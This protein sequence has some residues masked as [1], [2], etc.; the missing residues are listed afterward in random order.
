MPHRAGRRELKPAQRLGLAALSEGTTNELT[1]EQYQHLT[2]VSRSQAA[3]DLAEL[4]ETGLIERVGG[5]RSTRYRRRPRSQSSQRHW[6]NERIR[7]GLADFCATRTTWP[8]AGDFKAAGRADLYVAASRYGGIGVWASELG[9]S[10]TA[11][12]EQQRPARSLRPLLRWTPAGIAFAAVLFGVAGAVIQP[13]RPAPIREA[14]AAPDTPRV[15]APTHLARTKPA[16]PRA[17]RTRTHSA[18]QS[19]VPAERRVELVAQRVA[20]S[21]V[22]SV[23]HATAR[24]STA[25]SGPTPLPAPA[26]GGSAP[27]PLPAPPGGS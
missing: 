27:T 19:R 8:T 16:R 21:T 24:P 18:P 6:T 20:A 5:G 12:V 17:R 10:R 11:R 22:S 13:R 25:G 26:A 1:R 23:R 7:A 15:A 14:A 3:Y 4:V 9:F 2:G